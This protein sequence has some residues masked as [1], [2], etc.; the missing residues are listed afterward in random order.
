[1]D[2]ICKYAILRYVPNEI[3]EEFINIGLVFFS[4]EDSYINIKITNKLGRI[5]QFDDEVDLDFLK[6]V[7]EGMY[8]DFS[9]NVTEGPSLEETSNPEYLERMTS[10]YVNQL[11]FSPI[12]TIMSDQT[13]LLED[14]E[15]LFKTYVYFDSKQKDRITEEKVKSIM[16]RVFKSN[17]VSKLFDSNK[18]F[19]LGLEEIKFDFAY[20]KANKP[21][22]IKTISFDY[23]S[24]NNKLITQV[25]K[26]WAWNFDKLHSNVGIQHENIQTLIYFKEKNEIIKSAIDILQE[27]SQITE[28]KSEENITN[29][30]N[31]IIEDVL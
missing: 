12:K 29:F 2:R 17:K 25:A 11:Q 14:Q 31:Q 15:D 10:I 5:R 6:I 7:L 28:A 18:K 16:K 19:D 3:R 20:E 8:E 13:L 21:I 26:E 30:A 23:S 22:L 1:M 9:G 24:K 27:V 4:P